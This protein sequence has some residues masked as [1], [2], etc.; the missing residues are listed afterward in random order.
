MNIPT[1]YIFYPY[2]DF[3]NHDLGQIDPATPL[4][5]M[6]QFANQ[7][8]A[9]CFNTNGWMK[10]T[11]S[12][13]N[14]K[15]MNNTNSSGL[16][17]KTP[18]TVGQVLIPKIIHCRQQGDEK[19]STEC[20]AEIAWTK[21]NP[22]YQYKFWT[23]T[24]CAEFKST[25][26][27]LFKY[28][29]LSLEGGIVIDSEVQPGSHAFGNLSGFF[30][31]YANEI[32]ATGT[33]SDQIIGSTSNHPYLTVIMNQLMTTKLNLMQILTETTPNDLW[34]YPSQYFS[35][36]QLLKFAE[37]HQIEVSPKIFMGNKFDYVPNY[38]TFK[39]SV[40]TALIQKVSK[41]PKRLHLIWLNSNVNPIQRPA[42]FDQNVQ[43]WRE[44]MPDWEISVWSDDNLDLCPEALTKISEAC[45][46]A[47]KADIARYFIIE[48][49]GGFYSDAD[50]TPLNCLDS[51]LCFSHQLI[52]CHDIPVTWEY[53]A[54][55]FFGA[56][57]HHP[58][59]QTACNLAM[60]AQ[61]NTSD[62]HL[63]TGPRLFGLAIW[64]TDLAPQKCLL[65]P[66]QCFYHNK[67][68]PYRFG[69]H[70]YAKEWA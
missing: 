67:D 11:F 68:N 53:I 44:L 37:H 55:G 21:L 57:P 43:K 9:V 4:D 29:I 25:S 48:K 50:I 49:Y 8:N 62:L 30:C 65:L 66:P 38:L 41:I 60:Q 19:S 61:L 16:Y 28:L 69:L 47:Q 7:H 17:V 51:L 20:D 46:G 39:P 13:L 23:P 24:M 15:L 45:Q 31:C 32:N 6:I 63:K 54:I 10:H 33:L 14:V 12:P 40:E 5:H 42:Y 52:V 27:D 26:P 35:T 36:K 1:Q 18:N 70:F 2:I 3:S 59:I 34:V 56:I 58:A 64:A 22:D